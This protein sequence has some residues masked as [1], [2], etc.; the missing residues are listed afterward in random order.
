MTVY[1]NRVRRA[2]L[3]KRSKRETLVTTLL[4]LFV[5]A[6]TG[7]TIDSSKASSKIISNLI[8]PVSCCHVVGGVVS[9]FPIGGAK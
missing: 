5:I 6:C 3:K 7:I 8:W 4:F 9:S 1:T 2:Y